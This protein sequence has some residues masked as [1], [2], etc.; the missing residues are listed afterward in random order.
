CA[1]ELERELPRPFAC[2][3][4][5][6]GADAERREPRELLRLGLVARGME[7]L[8]DAERRPS[9]RKRGRDGAI[10]RQP[11]SMSTDRPGL[12]ERALAD[13]ACSSEI[14]AGVD[15][16]RGG[17]DEPAFAALPEDGRRRAG[18]AGGEADDLR[19]G[20]LLLQCDRERL[21][22]E[23]ESRTRERGDVAAQREGAEDE[24]GLGGTELRGEP[25]F[26]GERLAAT[27]QLERD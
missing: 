13:L 26:G 22:G 3:Q 21:A 25:L 19:R 14:G 6:G 4:R 5:V 23:L 11:C 9:Q 10:L 27:Q 7:Q 15:A 17:G 8:Q 18:D 1:L 12:G 16:P 20:V 2:A 24:R